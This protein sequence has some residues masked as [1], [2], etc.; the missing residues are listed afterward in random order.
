MKDQPPFP[1][2]E[3]Q[4]RRL[5]V[6]LAGLE[7]EL[8]RLRETLGHPRGDL[9]L[10]R[11][12]EPIGPAEA[13]MLL[14]AIEASERQLRRMADELDLKAEVE[15]VRRTFLAGLE[16]AGIG[17]YEMRPAGALGGYGALAPSTAAYLEAELPR[18]EALV[19]GLVRLLA[20]A[21]P[22]QAPDP[23]PP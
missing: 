16:L 19:E 14:P 8:R 3:S 20:S 21:P 13:E 11:P 17:L 5:T 2:T 7:Q 10:T 23:S 15:P 12:V 4:R 9:R 1:L 22:P 18:L 6:T